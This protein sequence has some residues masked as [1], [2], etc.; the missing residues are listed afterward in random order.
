VEIYQTTKSPWGVGNVFI[1]KVIINSEIFVAIM[2]NRI[3]IYVGYNNIITID[4]GRRW[5][6]NAKV[7]NKLV[8]LNSFRNSLSYHPIFNFNKRLENSGCS[9]EC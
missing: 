8:N 7:I 1:N 6:T 5:K 9:L 3:C 4:L 2:L